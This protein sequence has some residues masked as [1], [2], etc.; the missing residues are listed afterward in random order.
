[1]KNHLAILDLLH[2]VEQ[3]TTKPVG[4]I[5]LPLLTRQ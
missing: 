5:L 2:A 3:D 4:A 1:M